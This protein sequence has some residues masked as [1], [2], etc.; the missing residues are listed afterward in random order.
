MASEVLKVQGF[1][2]DGLRTLP[3][4]LDRTSWK[5]EDITEKKWPQRSTYDH[6]MKRA[7][8]LCPFDNVQRIIR[9]SLCDY[10]K[11]AFCGRHFHAAKWI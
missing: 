7:A 10:N 2:R 5:N 11:Y 1:Q 6:V 9:V 8:C 4:G 3:A